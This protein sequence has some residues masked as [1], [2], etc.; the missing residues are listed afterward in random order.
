LGCTAGCDQPAR[1]QD[2]GALKDLKAAALETLKRSG[3]EIS[4][5]LR[6]H[7]VVND[8]VLLRMIANHGA[9]LTM[10]KAKGR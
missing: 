6:E 4:I 9:A 5:K 10:L 3:S 7:P 1:G 2:A 8:P